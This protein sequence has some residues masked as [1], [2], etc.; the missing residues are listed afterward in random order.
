MEKNINLI[1]KELGQYFTKSQL[2]RNHVHSLIKNNPKVILEP[3]VG[4]GDL[5]VD[6]KDKYDFVMYEI[7]ES[8]T[9]FLIDKKLIIFSDFLVAQIDKKFDTIIGNPPFVVRKKIIICIL[10]LS[11][12]VMTCSLIM[13]R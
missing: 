12:N 10:L 6:I 13:V 3:S 2:L 4:R 11:K 5:V 7:D 9:D 1:K 8:I